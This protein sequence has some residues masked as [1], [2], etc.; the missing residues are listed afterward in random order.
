MKR[1]LQGPFFPIKGTG[2]LGALMRGSEQKWNT[3][4]LLDPVPVYNS[5]WLWGAKP[6]TLLNFQKEMSE[7]CA[8]CW[9]LLMREFPPS[10][11]DT[12]WGSLTELNWLVI[13]CI[14]CTDR[15]T[16]K[17]G[18]L[19]VH[20]WSQRGAA[21]W[22]TISFCLTRLTPLRG[23]SGGWMGSDL[24]QVG[25]EHTWTLVSPA[26]WMSVAKKWFYLW[27]PLL[28]SYWDLA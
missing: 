5:P 9:C 24:W 18:C 21:L 20:G 3:A 27:S 12:C 1:L 15:V 10:S 2:D 14:C 6:I 19:S 28:V 23:A 13:S 17:Q 4:F 7:W 8:S 16:V 25:W 22:N 11:K 26:V